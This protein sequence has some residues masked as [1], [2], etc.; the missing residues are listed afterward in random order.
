ME[1]FD[2]PTLTGLHYIQGL[3]DG[4]VLGKEALAGFPS[5][6]TLPHTASL[7]FHGVNVHGS[8]SKNKSM[9]LHI[10]NTV[11]NKK[12]E[13]IAREM[14][15]ERVFFGWPFLYEG[16]VSAVSDGL[17][18]YDKMAVV[19]GAPLKVVSNPHSP[20]AIGMWKS[21]AERIE[22]TYSK[23]CG[24]LTGDVDVLLHIRPLR[25]RVPLAYRGIL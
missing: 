1:P 11:E 8:E 2:L 20:G 10:T 13:E 12:T 23:R 19:P 16:L 4:V 9:V 15:G 14:V 21:K 18:K 25:G 5:L 24:V 3:C 6:Q 7:G 17:F 22:D